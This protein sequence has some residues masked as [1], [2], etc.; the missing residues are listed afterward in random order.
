[1]SPEPQHWSLAFTTE[2]L[3]RSVQQTPFACL[4]DPRERLSLDI[5][6]LEQQQANMGSVC[7]SLGRGRHSRE[8]EASTVCTSGALQ[9]EEWGLMKPM[10]PSFVTI[11][12]LEYPAVL[13]NPFSLSWHFLCTRCRTESL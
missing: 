11:L 2:P 6:P 13:W 1:M 3:E 10:V 9:A 5:F 7:V 8:E 4:G 12:S